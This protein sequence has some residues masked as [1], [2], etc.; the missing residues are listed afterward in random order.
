MDR[1]EIIYERPYEFE[2]TVI[3]AKPDGV[4]EK[5]TR[6]V[7]IT[8]YDLVMPDFNIDF[9]RRHTMITSE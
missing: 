1:T 5:E 9:D 4:D 8:W 2:V 7:S 3:W 6:T